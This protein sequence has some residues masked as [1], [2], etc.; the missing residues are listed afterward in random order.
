MDVF[1]STFTFDIYMNLLVE[2]KGLWDDGLKMK[3]DKHPQL[4]KL[5]FFGKGEKIGW[6]GKHIL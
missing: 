2:I 5:D 6:D 3:R 4:T 1:Q